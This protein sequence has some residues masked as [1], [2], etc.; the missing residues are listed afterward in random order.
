MQTFT[1]KRVELCEMSKVFSYSKLVNR[2]DFLC[3]KNGL[4]F[5][6]KSVES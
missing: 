3:S 4:D 6:L 5:H 1:G 2:G